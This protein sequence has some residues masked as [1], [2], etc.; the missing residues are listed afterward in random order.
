MNTK[1]SF[2]NELLIIEAQDRIAKILLNEEELYKT[3]PIKQHKN[4]FYKKEKIVKII[5]PVGETIH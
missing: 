4:I 5:M 1:K 3:D 2:K